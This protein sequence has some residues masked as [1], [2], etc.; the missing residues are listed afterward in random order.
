MFFRVA[1]V[2]E[3]CNRKFSKYGTNSVKIFYKNQER[4]AF[5]NFTSC[6]DAKRA[7]HAKTGLLWE[8]MQ[9][10]LEP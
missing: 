10:A 8:N 2:R 4:V 9:V 1:E 6:D 3:L 5:V 7:R